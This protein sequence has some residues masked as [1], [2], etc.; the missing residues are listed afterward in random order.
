MYDPDGKVM[1][2]QD[3]YSKLI[4]GYDFGANLSYINDKEKNELMSAW[5]NSKFE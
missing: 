3:M 1:L 5:K 4:N 2:Y